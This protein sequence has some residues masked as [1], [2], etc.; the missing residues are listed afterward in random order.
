ME[1][2]N[3]LANLYLLIRLLEVESVSKKKVDFIYC[4]KW[5]KDI[6]RA[7]T[8]CQTVYIFYLINSPYNLVL[9]VLP[10]LL[11]MRKQIW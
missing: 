6:Y 3:F 8:I 7:S 10:Q 2:G 4:K 9:W 11:K 1:S 5:G